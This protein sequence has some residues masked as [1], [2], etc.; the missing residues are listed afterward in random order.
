MIFHDGHVHTPFCPHGSKDELEEYVLRA[1][2]LG[3]T[4]LTFTEHAP[5]PLSFE[6]P[7]PEQDSAKIFIEQIC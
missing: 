3:L 2:E 7:T 1:I 5:L 4:G 6:D